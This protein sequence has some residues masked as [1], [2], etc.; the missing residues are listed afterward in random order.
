MILHSSTKTGSVRIAPRLSRNQAVL[1]VLDCAG[2]ITQLR[3]SPDDMRR[4]AAALMKVAA[5]LE[6]SHQ[7]EEATQP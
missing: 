2:E 6:S 3:L 4:L 1:E 5:A 7:S